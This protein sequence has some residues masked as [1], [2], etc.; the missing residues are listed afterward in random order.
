MSETR[1]RYAPV[2]FLCG[3]FLLVAGGLVYALDRP[4]GSVVFLPPAFVHDSGLLGPIAGSLPSFLHAMAFS[5]M[6]AALLM[7]TLRMRAAACGA[8]LAFNW[9][10]EIAQASVF[11]QI[12]GIGMSGT[13]DPQDMLATVLGSTCAFL[14]IQ[15]TAPRG[16]TR[17]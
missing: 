12:A 8:W 17:K 10:F 6:T 16:G 9:V 5:M 4:A 15:A 1:T 13:F 3:L 2:P 14:V 11:R 7:P